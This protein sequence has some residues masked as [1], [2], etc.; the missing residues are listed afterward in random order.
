MCRFPPSTNEGIF[1]HNRLYK[2]CDERNGN[3][4]NLQNA[5]VL[6]KTCKPCHVF[7]TEHQ[8]VGQADKKIGN[9]FEINL[10]SCL[11]KIR[12]NISKIFSRN[13][14]ILFKQNQVAERMKYQFSRKAQ[15]I[16]L[17]LCPKRSNV[18]KQDINASKHHQN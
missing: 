12:S 8:K 16:A 15:P 10:L 14:I 17:N 6:K 7:D 1:R 11:S 18:T 4:I 5:H 13:R 3:I 2:Q 9:T